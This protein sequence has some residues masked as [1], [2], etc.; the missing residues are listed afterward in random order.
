MILTLSASW[1][2]S[3]LLAAGSAGGPDYIG[4]AAIIAA[5]ASAFGTIIATV[6]TLLRYL[7]RDEPLTADDLADAVQHAVATELGKRDEK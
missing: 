7:N 6:I 5:A 3:G 1:A 2:T 4:I